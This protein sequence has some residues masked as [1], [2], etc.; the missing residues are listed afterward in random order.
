[1]AQEKDKIIEEYLRNLRTNASIEI[2]DEDFYIIKEAVCGYF[3]K[4]IQQAKSEGIAQG[5]KE[6]IREE[7]YFLGSLHLTASARDKESYNWVSINKIAE[8]VRELKK[9]LGEEH[10]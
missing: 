6:Q 7:L 1:M 2:S 5:R 8:R 10:E 9:E 3:E 4:F